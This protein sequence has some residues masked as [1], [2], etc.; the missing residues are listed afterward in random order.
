MEAGLFSPLTFTKFLERVHRPIRPAG[1]PTTTAL[2]YKVIQ[3]WYL[4]GGGKKTLSFKRREVWAKL[5]KGVE[6][7]QLA[8]SGPAPLPQ[9][10][11][12]RQL[13]TPHSEDYL[14]S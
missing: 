4:L 8:Y 7:G 2:F 12:N 5:F 11:I 3:N 13:L 10:G 1:K 6:S 14:K 9:K